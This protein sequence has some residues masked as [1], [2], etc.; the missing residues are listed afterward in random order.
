MTRYGGEETPSAA[1][2]VRAY[3]RAVSGRITSFSF[4]ADTRRGTLVFAAEPGV[5]E[6]AAPARLYPEGVA[7][8]LAGVGGRVAW[9]AAR[10]LLL[11]ET[12]G[13][14]AATISFGPGGV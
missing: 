6:L 9:D 5:T 7:G 10:G 1:A 13:A 4:E 12:T 8:T 14:G 3:P 2:L 11:V